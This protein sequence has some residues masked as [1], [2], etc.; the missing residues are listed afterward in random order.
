LEWRTDFDASG[1]SRKSH[2][3]SLY[4]RISFEDEICDTL[5]AEANR[6]IA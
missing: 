3:V 2:S 1:V 4:K 5:T 6:A